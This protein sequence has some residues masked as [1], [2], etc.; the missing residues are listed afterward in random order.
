VPR[1]RRPPPDPG[2]PLLGSY[3]SGDIVVQL[4]RLLLAAGA[5]LRVTAR[6]D[7]RTTAAVAAFKRRNRLGRGGYVTAATWERLLELE[8][9]AVTWR[10]RR[11]AVARAAR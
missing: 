7:R 5:R 4:Q 1:L 9:A 11:Y 2:Y 3:S 6:M 10:A 8:P